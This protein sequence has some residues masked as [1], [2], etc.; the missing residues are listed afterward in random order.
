[1]FIS[2][3]IQIFVEVKEEIFCFSFLQDPPAK[4]Q[5]KKFITTGFTELFICKVVVVVV[6]EN[7][8][9]YRHKQQVNLIT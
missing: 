2:T 5:F 3:K 9:L 8:I 6:D 1:M 4:F 7:E